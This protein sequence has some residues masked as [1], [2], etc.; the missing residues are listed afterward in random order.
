MS[1][2]QTRSK[3][4]H[5]AYWLAAVLTV[6]LLAILVKVGALGVL[7]MVGLLGVTLLTPLLMNRYGLFLFL[8]LFIVPSFD[9]VRSLLVA[10]T[11]PVVF[12]ITGLTLPFA[13]WLV[14]RDMGKVTKALPFA[15]FLLLFNG[16]LCLNIPR[17][18]A[19]PGVPLECLKL[20]FE[21]FVLFCG[22]R[23]MVEG[24]WERLFNQLNGFMIFNSGVAFFQRLTGIGLD[25]IEGL[26]RVGGLV[27]HPNCLAFLNALYIPFGIARLLQAKTTQQRIFWLVGVVA[28]TL[29][30]LLTLCK[31]VIFCMVLDYAVLFLF[32]PNT[33][34]R[35]CL[36]VLVLMVV[37]LLSANALFDLR[38]FAMFS[39][40]LGNNDSMAWRFKIWRELLGNMDGA[41]LLVGHGVNAGKALV[42]QVVPG[43]S[44]F[45]HNIYIQ[46]LY[47]YG[48]TGFALIAAFLQP[49]M[50]FLRSLWNAKG[51]AERL[52]AVLPLLI[53]LTIF[54][55]MATD[56]SVFLR[57]PMCFAWLFL[58]YFYLRRQQRLL[59]DSNNPG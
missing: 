48:A 9:N 46:L 31:S 20:F 33:L 59:G 26:P 44:M 52:N 2:I 53:L 57:T 13:F 6:G 15:G 21:A 17:P 41:T 42:H 7:A 35:R 18:D 12:L 58:A 1:F 36:A 28:A 56:N 8:W 43:D 30:L 45:I 5:T 29:A 47:E 19:E 24:N 51:A 11:N 39:E 37:L 25:V 49:A 40:R 22:Y 4:H 32:L 3:P 23:V 16:M 55:N 38:L 54:I 34:K 10:G 50:Q 27:G 14:G